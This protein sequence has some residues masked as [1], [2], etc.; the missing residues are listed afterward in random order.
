MGLRITYVALVVSSLALALDTVLALSTLVTATPAI[1]M[2]P[3]IVLFLLIFPLHL[4]TV[5]GLRGKFRCGGLRQRLRSRGRLGLGSLEK[6]LP[7]R[8][9][10]IAAAMFFGYWLL[11]VSALIHLGA[12]D[13]ERHQGRF[14]ADNHGTLT[15]ISQGAY[16][17][18]EVNQLRV[19]TAVPAA[20]FLV[21]AVYNLAV[22]RGARRGDPT[23]IAGAVQ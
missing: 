2:R 1:S 19:F 20:F 16:D 6:F 5:L 10:L 7:R 22:L 9:V 8:L 21:A 13:P 23:P 15:L 14:F 3:V 4:R 11:G 12:G 18:L 17:R